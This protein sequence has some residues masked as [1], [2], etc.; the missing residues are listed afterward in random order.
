M[1]R[2]PDYE[3]AALKVKVVV[4]LVGQDTRLF[5]PLS[6]SIN[7]HYRWISVTIS[8]LKYANHY[9]TPKKPMTKPKYFQHPC[10]SLA[11]RPFCTLKYAVMFWIMHDSLC[12]RESIFLISWRSKIHRT[13]RFKDIIYTFVDLF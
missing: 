2:L 11:P 13:T 9:S 4:L 10:Y 8:I 12:K 5:F 1:S 3:C 7:T 6:F